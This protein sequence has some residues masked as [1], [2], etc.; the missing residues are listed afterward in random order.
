MDQMLVA[1]IAAAL[2]SSVDSDDNPIDSNYTPEDLHPDTFAIMKADVEK[3][4][5]ENESDI[6]ERYEDAGHDFWLTRNRHGC[7]FWETPDWPK[8]A[9]KRLTEASHRAGER[10]LFIDENGKV[11][12]DNC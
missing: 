1:Y 5:R 3:F 10:N 4:L 6:G 7:G 8:E 12:Q 11:C 9:G 2:W